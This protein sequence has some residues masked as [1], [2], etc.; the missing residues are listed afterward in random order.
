MGPAG[1][2]G[3]SGPGGPQG[4]PGGAAPVTE[5]T[6]LAVVAG[7][8]GTGTATAQCSSDKYAVSG[9]FFVN[10][11]SPEERSQ[12]SMFEWRPQVRASDSIIDGY[13]ASF[14]NYGL[15]TLGVQ[16]VI[17]CAALP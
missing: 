14:V 6:A 13:R 7:S 11:T 15:T 10:A 17:E 8:G 2:A 1:P 9:G 4:A 16:L 12:V 3:P 5:T